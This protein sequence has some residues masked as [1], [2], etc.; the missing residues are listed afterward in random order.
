M[1][2]TRS[3]FCA[4]LLALVAS[5]CDSLP[6]RPAEASPEV[7]AAERLFAEGEFPAAA[8]AF[9]DAARSSRRQ[10]DALTLRAAEA[11]RENGEIERARP[12]LE[13]LNERRLLADELLRLNLLRAELALIERQPQRALDVLAGRLQTAPAELQD[14]ILF[15]RAQAHAGLD[16]PF[17]AARARAALAQYLAPTERDAN[18]EAIRSLLGQIRP[19]A[20]QRDAAGLDRAD[21]VY[22]HVAASLRALGLAMPTPRGVVTSSSSTRAQ[23]VALLLPRSGPLGPAGEAVRDGFM[24][25]YFAD[26]GPRPEV[27]VYDAGDSVEQNLEAFRS[28]SADGVDR[29]VGPLSREAVSAL[30][31][32]GTLQTPLLA[33]NRGSVTPPPGSQSFALSPEDEGLAAAQRLLALGYR[34]VITANGG[35]EHARRVLAALTPEFARGGGQIVAEITPP[36]GSPDYS[37][38]IGRALSAAGR[39]VPQVAGESDGF[40][41]DA[42]FLAVRT[43]QAR[44]LVPQLRS[45]GVFDRP[46]LAS[47]QIR[48]GEAVSR[49][50]RDF[51]GIEFSELPWMLG[52]SAPGLP[53]RED[54]SALPSAR[55]ASARLF[56][57]GIDAYRVLAALPALSRMPGTAIDGATGSLSLDD[58]GQVRRLPAWGR[59]NGARVRPAPAQE[60]LALDVGAGAG[61][62]R[63]APRGAGPAPPAI[64]RARPARGQCALPLRRARPGHGRGRDPGLHRSA[65]SAQRQSW[66]RAGLGQR[67][68]ASAP[69]EGRPGLSCRAARTRQTPLPLRPGRNRGRERPALAARRDR[70]RSLVE[71]RRRT[72]QLAAPFS[73]RP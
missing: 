39:R 48:S 70:G 54:L 49:L 10:R 56:A 58:F 47:S 57:F 45:A 62:L 21:P 2:R 55:G 27:L 23:R 59:F 30:F 42:L 22:D 20:L 9:L 41:I 53:A 46:I 8:Q 11:W 73:A 25:A 64:G 33:L 69:V 63:S 68:Q 61:H 24:S 12:L 67:G 52:A 60:S 6:T 16:Q 72:P 5:G 40:D 4:L 44:L 3:L 1:T 19:A 7:Q 36:T 38:A 37:A 66:R 35:D 31:E 32:L 29:I 13:T 17:E 50:D 34:R 43:E 51:D 15:I 28:A 71:P 18:A 26:P 65:L 14:R